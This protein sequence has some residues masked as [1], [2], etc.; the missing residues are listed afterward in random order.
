MVIKNFEMT[1]VGRRMD[2]IPIIMGQKN[3]IPTSVLTYNSEK[4]SISYG[5]TNGAIIKKTD[6]TRFM[7]DTK[8][9]HALTGTGIFVLGKR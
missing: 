7:N 6:D 9:T 3:Q 2:A 1:L 5:N 4:S 8:I